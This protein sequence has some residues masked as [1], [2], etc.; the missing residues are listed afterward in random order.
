MARNKRTCHCDAYEFPH[1]HGSG[2]CHGGEE[3]R[4]NPRIYIPDILVWGAVAGGAYYGWK[5]GWFSQFGINPPS[6][7][8][9]TST[10]CPTTTSS[11]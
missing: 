2:K 7:S 10:T 3:V 8:G 9:S 5:Q 1:R 6:S 4:T 11:S